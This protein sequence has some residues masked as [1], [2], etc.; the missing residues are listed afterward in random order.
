MLN[1]SCIERS[2]SVRFLGVEVDD[3]LK[4]KNHINEVSRKISKNTGIFSKLSYFIP[5]YVLINLYHSLIESYLN[6]CPII[7]GG[8]C[9]TH[10]RPLE[11]AQRKCIRI[12]CRV[13]WRSNTDH[14]FLNLKILKFRDIYRLHLGVHMYKNPDICSNLM[15]NHDHN[16]RNP[17]L[18][19]PYQRLTLTQR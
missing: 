18:S 3:K 7:F 2:S 16:L 4:F 11:V 19:R 6:Y 10:L 15:I 13:D 12:I 5:K 14:L 17:S 1:N 9:I 8:A